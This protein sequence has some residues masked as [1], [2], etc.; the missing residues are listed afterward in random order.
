MYPGGGVVQNRPRL[1]VISRAP[2]ASRRS[3]TLEFKAL[4][5]SGALQ[6]GTDATRAIS[7]SRNREV[8]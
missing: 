2:L 5:E 3:L 8:T 4:E 6:G 1:V 7:D